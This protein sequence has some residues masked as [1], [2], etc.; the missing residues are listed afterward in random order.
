MAITMKVDKTDGIIFPLTDDNKVTLTVTG[1][2]AATKYNISIVDMYSGD[3]LKEIEKTGITTITD[4][5]LLQ[6]RD[7]F[8]HMFLKHKNYR[9]FRINIIL[10]TVTSSA[11][12]KTSEL[13]IVVTRNNEDSQT[14]LAAG[15]C[16]NDGFDDIRQYSN[17]QPYYRENTVTS[18]EANKMY[19][20]KFVKTHLPSFV[21]PI[22]VESNIK[23]SD[24]DYARI[25]VGYKTSVTFYH[26]N[27]T[28][29]KTSGGSYANSSFKI[30][31]TISSENITIDDTI[32]DLHKGYK[33][34]LIKLDYITIFQ[35]FNK[36]LDQILLDVRQFNPTTYPVGGVR[37]SGN[38]YLYIYF[39][40]VYK[41]GTISTRAINIILMTS[42]Q[43][44]YI[45]N[46][47]GYQVCT[48]RVYIHP[49][50]SVLRVPTNF[51]EYDGQLNTSTQAAITLY[52]FTTKYDYTTYRLQFSFIDIPKFDSSRNEIVDSYRFI[53]NLNDDDFEKIAINADVYV[54][55]QRDDES[56]YENIYIEG[57]A[58]IGTFN[59]DIPD[60]YINKYIDLKY[61]I[62]YPDGKTEDF[63]RKN[64]STYSDESDAKK[65]IFQV[66]NHGKSIVLGNQ[67]LTTDETINGDLKI[68]LS[69]KESNFNSVNSDIGSGIITSSNASIIRQWFV[70]GGY[71]CNLD[72][73]PST[74]KITFDGK[75]ILKPEVIYEHKF[76]DLYSGNLTNPMYFV[77]MNGAVLTFETPRSSKY[78]HYKATTNANNGFR[79]DTMYIYEPNTDY[80]VQFEIK[81]SGDHKLT[82]IRF[83]N[84]KKLVFKSFTVD[85]CD[86]GTVFATNNLVA[87]SIINNPGRH[88][89]KIVYTTPASVQADTASNSTYYDN[90]IFDQGITTAVKAAVE[91]DMYNF[92]ILKGDH[93]NDNVEWTPG[94][95]EDYIIAPRYFSEYDKISIQYRMKEANGVLYVLQGTVQSTDI[96]K[97]QN[98]EIVS[99][100]G[101]EVNQLN[102]RLE[103]HHK[104]FT[105]T[106]KIMHMPEKRKY[107]P[108][109]NWH[110]QQGSSFSRG[111]WLDVIGVYGWH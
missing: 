30:A 47:M 59:I 88:I 96:W 9:F 29:A 89:V 20:A 4:T 83:N 35:I 102:G 97:P 33:Y 110:I 58:R 93:S 2:T 36:Y 45:D 111:N 70:K 80:T 5:E 34:A 100:D 48:D 26:P 46:M 43:P 53:T 82:N 71:T 11:T 24:I 64:V 92:Q 39:D 99:L 27:S 10:Y 106:D 109:M 21:Y 73:N 84:T 37:I 72:I 78:L 108:Y 87:A 54:K 3:I 105:F 31:K 19:F 66:I 95:Y 40:I 67:D 56:S 18:I 17:S 107:V 38:P 25:R 7:N 44:Q 51:I 98:G 52:S 104:E 41:D 50:T 77:T 103:Y 61:H 1:L 101:F 28:G 22:C 68:A 14:T 42:E 85:G 60:S 6:N 15:F 32:D 69:G 62:R 16:M 8:E 86:C 65:D 13:Q 55:D 57:L 90:I 76:D 91:F 79:F 23:Y 94:I 49:T 75:D 81:M 74:K 12:T 63:V